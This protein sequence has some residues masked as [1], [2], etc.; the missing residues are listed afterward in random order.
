VPQDSSP[1]V[2]SGIPE[3]RSPAVGRHAAHTGPEERPLPDE[4]LVLPSFITGKSEPLP[5]RSQPIPA[6]EPAVDEPAPDPDRLPASERGM[7][8]FVASLLGLGGLA[9]IVILGLGGFGAPAPSAGAATTA[10][11]ESTVPGPTPSPTPSLTASSPV[12]APPPRPSTTTK[13]PSPTQR[14]LGTLSAKDPAAFC[15]SLDAGRVSQHSDHSWYC[16]GSTGHPQSLPFTSTD[17]CRWR[18][19]DKT[20]YAVAADIDQ[21]STWKCYT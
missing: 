8:I 17:V 16:R 5:E 12:P 6:A 11:V 10:P 19:L 14:L 2:T 9:V 21:P 18:Y 1:R 15:T 7:L 3:Q 13:R 20:A 4:T